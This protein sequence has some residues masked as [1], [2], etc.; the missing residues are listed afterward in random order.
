MENEDWKDYPC[1]LSD[2]V[3]ERNGYVKSWTKVAG[4]RYE[5][6]IAY[7]ITYNYRFKPEDECCHHCD[8][9]I[10]LQPKHMF[11]GTRQDNMDDMVKKNRQARGEHNG[12]AKLSEKEVEEI[13]QLSSQYTQT[14]LA[15]KYNVSQFAIWSILSGRTWKDV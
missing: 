15:N 12:N 2:K 7:A 10:C 5:H 3:P 1:I 4:E 14:Y 9:K 8:I 13:K 6:R 11:L